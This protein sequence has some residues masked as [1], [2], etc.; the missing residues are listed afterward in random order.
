YVA[1]T[2]EG[3]IYPCHQFVGI[4]SFKIGNVNN[5]TLNLDIVNNFSKS[6]ISSKEE[7]SHCWV[8]FYCGGGCA[9]NNYSFNKDINKSYK[10][11]CELEKKRV[12]CALW[13]KTQL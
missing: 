8:K 7:C 11:G 12:E 3:D 1:V 9:A 6:N 13:I 4:E 5:G 10:I 2:P